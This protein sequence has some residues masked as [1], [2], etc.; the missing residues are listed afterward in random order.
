MPMGDMGGKLAIGFG[1]IFAIIVFG[2]TIKE[3][4]S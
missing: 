1:V 2:V 4:M 3:V